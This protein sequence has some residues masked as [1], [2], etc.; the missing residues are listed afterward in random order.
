MSRA[1]GW[2]AGAVGAV[3][4]VAL[5]VLMS[6]TASGA[7]GGLTNVT[8]KLVGWS[9][10]SPLPA[11]V[12]ID[13][14]FTDDGVSGT[15][16]VNRYRG[17]V[18]IGSEGTLEVG[19]LISTLMAGPDDAMAAEHTFLTLLAKATGYTVSDGTLVLT[20]KAGTALLTFAS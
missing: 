2:A 16:G 1:A 8:W 14:V 12:S 13:A 18:T 6:V 10:T 15:S 17:G 20:D 9:A 19:P 7:E 11:T 5:A 4:A 3:V